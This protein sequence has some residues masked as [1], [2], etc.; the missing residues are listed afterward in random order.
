MIAALL[1]VIFTA[2]NT[3]AILHK[4]TIVAQ[5][6]SEGHVMIQLALEEGRVLVGSLVSCLKEKYMCSNVVILNSHML[7]QLTTC[8]FVVPMDTLVVDAI[9]LD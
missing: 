5:Q 4:R 8:V 1:L 6:N 9:F 3:A 2:W 7:L